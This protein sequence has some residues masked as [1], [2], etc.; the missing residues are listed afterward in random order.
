MKVRILSKGEIEKLISINEAIDVVRNVFMEMKDE[1]NNSL[2]RS[3]I[4]VNEGHLLC[5]PF[6]LP[7]EGKLGAKIIAV[8]PKARKKEGK[9]ISGIVILCSAETGRTLCLMD[10]ESITS[11]R[12]GAISAVASDILS[13]KAS[14]VLSL[15]GAGVQGR[16]QVEALIVVRRIEKVKIF[17]IN[18]EKARALAE[19]LKKRHRR[20]SEFY[21]VSSPEEA[22]ADADIIV[23]A[24]TSCRP[25]FDGNLV[26]EG[27]HVIAIGSFTPQCRELD[28]ALLS[29]AKIVVD[30]YAQSLKEA[31]DIII[32]MSNNS[33][34]ESNIY[35]ELK[36]LIKG[37]K[38][39]RESEE[40]ITVFKS[41]GLAIQDAALAH[42][43]FEKAEQ[44]NAGE[45]LS[46]H[47]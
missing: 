8:F 47:D 12:T 2:E 9:T 31:G 43:V 18:F 22:V 42:K 30:S 10:A 13:R 19:E 28:D 14:R 3:V 5:M 7:E 44:Q 26:K 27:A 39:G 1:N 21:S 36:E 20:Q 29:R 32:A 24:T 6:Y 40:E 38:K 16:A 46:I 23:T 37:E 41:V 34:R 4:E 11:L 33:I 15:F 35:G 17:D 25:V 45:M